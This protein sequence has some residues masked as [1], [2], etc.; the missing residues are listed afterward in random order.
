MPSKSV[1]ANTYVLDGK[2][3]T[4][5]TRILDVIKDDGIEAWKAKV[6]PEEAKRI[7]EEA[8]DFG[9]RVHTI[10]EG[11]NLNPTGYRN[12]DAEL[13]P[14]YDSYSEWFHDNVIEVLGSE[15]TVR[16]EHYR[17][18][19]TY[20]MKLRLRDERPYMGD[21]KTNRTAV[22]PKARL[23]MAAYVQAEREDADELDALDD[24]T[25]R[26]VIWMPSSKPGKLVPLF[27]DDDQED[28]YVFESAIR[29]FRWRETHKN[30]WKKKL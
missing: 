7:L 24:S 5:V 15:T 4:R 18:A 6:G 25:G 10:V 27:F 9:T 14:W 16:S 8:S 23:Q 20:D 17:Y 12:T 11:V 28:W 2:H 26:L 30:D 1:N 3:Y 22:S 21:A 13:E 19:G 29:L